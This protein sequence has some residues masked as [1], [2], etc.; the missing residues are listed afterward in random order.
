M[1]TISSLTGASVQVSALARQIA[2]SM[3]SNN[4]GQV[5]IVEFGSFIRN[6]LQGSSSLSAVADKGSGSTTPAKDAAALNFMP[7]F[8]GFDASRSVSAAGTLKYDAYNVLKDYD[9]RDPTAMR[10]AFAVL[11]AM[12][13]GQYE[14]DAQDNLMLTG[15]ADGY[16]GARPVNRDSDWT[17][18][19]QDWSWDW[20]AYNTA[21]PGPNGE[22]T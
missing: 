7:M 11:D 1:S 3:D 17:N 4:D 15:T 10:S 22:L 14:L 20:F 8:R 5:S 18:R 12:H 13:P 19:A 16:I 21:H 2:T 6:I 9:P